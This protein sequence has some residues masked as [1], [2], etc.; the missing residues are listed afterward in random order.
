MNIKTYEEFKK[1]SKS[2]AL[3][4]FYVNVPN[5]DYHAS[6]GISKSGLDLVSKS[7]AHYKFSE[8][9]KT[10]PALKLGTAIHSAI[11]EPE[12]FATEYMALKTVEDRRKSEYKEAVKTFGADNVLIK[13]ETLIIDGVTESLETNQDAME[14][15]SVPGWNEVSVFATDENGILLKCRFDRLAENG[16]AIDIKTTKDATAYGFSKSVN[17]YRYHVQA[18]FYGYVFKLATGK[19]LIGF[20]FIALEKEAPFCNKV[21]TL[22]PEAVEIGH[23]YMRKDL[24]LYTE[25]YNSDYWAMPDNSLEEIGLPNW[26]YN[27][28]EEELEQEIK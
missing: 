26:A 19:D 3:N 13:Q 9:F 27:K 6:P 15:L 2:G 17:D 22:E 7:P 20:T 14:I 11:L 4:G 8:P 10:T 21:F 1:D 25:A 5:A 12:L 16:L 24:Q 18:A 28:Y 23:F